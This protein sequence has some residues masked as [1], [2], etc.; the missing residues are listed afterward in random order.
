MER[1]AVKRKPIKHTYTMKRAI[2][3][4]LMAAFYKV[5]TYLYKRF[6]FI[7]SVRKEHWKHQAESIQKRL[8]VEHELSEMYNQREGT[9]YTTKGALDHWNSGII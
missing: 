6:G 9:F 5:D 3:N 7:S 2:S 8:D 1:Q 4:F